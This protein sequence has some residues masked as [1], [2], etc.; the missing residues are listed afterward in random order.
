LSGR[1]NIC[2][3]YPKQL[4]W[5]AAGATGRER[6]FLAGNQL[7]KTL[8]SGFEAACHSTGRYPP[9]WSGRR[10]DGPTVG[11]VAGTTN[12]A[13][14]DTVQR[15]LVGRNGDGTGAI[16]RD[17][18]LEMTPARGTPDL[19]DSIKVQHVSGAVSV[20]GVKSYQR[21][22]E[23]FQGETPSWIWL[24]EEPPIDIY[25]E[26]LT[27]TNVGQGPIWLTATPLLG[28]SDTVGRFLLEPS[29]DRH[30]TTMTID[31]VGH[32][33][34][35]ERAKIIASIPRTSARRAPGASRQSRPDCLTCSCEWRAGGSRSSSI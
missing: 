23:S 14:R 13:T 22:R 3:P 15:I 25:T 26:C 2:K 9:W 34:A 21:Q 17:A 5:H 16:P 1:W 33:S 12:E 4:Q 35:E 19:L 7:G 6:I 10:F 27:R 31:D 20:I 32:F 24:D 11:W 29:A 30:V 8:A 28:M 18:I